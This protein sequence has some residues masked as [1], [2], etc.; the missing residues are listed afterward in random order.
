MWYVQ[1]STVFCFT[2]T[3]NNSTCKGP[4][5][6]VFE[7]IFAGYNRL[8]RPVRNFDQVID[9]HLQLV[10]NGLLDIVSQNDILTF[11]LN[12]VFY[13]ISTVSKVFVL[14]L[15]SQLDIFILQY[16]Y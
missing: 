16:S 11:R 1:P 7:E 3:A 14:L 12:L 4:E 9:V 5:A 13:N 6:C 15:L 10:V 2:S 8:V